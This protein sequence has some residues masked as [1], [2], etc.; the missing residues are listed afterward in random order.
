[1][2]LHIDLGGLQVEVSDELEVVVAE[3]NLGKLEEGLVEVEVPARRDVEVVGDVPREPGLERRGVDL[4]VLQVHLV[5][6]DDGGDV[7]VVE[8]GERPKL[9]E[10][11]RDV[12]ERGP[13]RYVEHDDGGL[14]VHVVHVAQHGVDLLARRVPDLENNLVHAIRVEGYCLH[15]CPHGCNV[16]LQEI[17][18]LDSRDIGGLSHAP[19]PNED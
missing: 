10:P 9:H 19:V 7:D 1:M 15:V 11:P 6:A 12:L 14:R 2:R 5:P 17:P 3:E 13:G 8:G 4:P 18:V 16:V